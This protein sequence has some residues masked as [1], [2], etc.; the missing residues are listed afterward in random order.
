MSIY[1]IRKIDFFRYF[2]N[3]KVE[4]YSTFSRHGRIEASFILLIWLI[5][6]VH[7]TNNK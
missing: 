7:F 5:E 2:C 6:N 4:F 3:E 1:S